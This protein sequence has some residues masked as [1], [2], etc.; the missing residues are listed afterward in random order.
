LIIAVIF[1]AF[2]GAAVEISYHVLD[3]KRL[4]GAVRQFSLI[5]ESNVP[6]WYSALLLTACALSLGVI[7]VTRPAGKGNYR[8]HWLILALIFLYMSMDEAAIIHEMTIRPIRDALH[9][10]GALY[11]AWTLPAAILMAIFLLSYLGF[12][13]HLPA[14]SR[15]RFILA[16][17]I[18][19]G[20]AFGTELIIGYLRDSEGYKFAS[21]FFSA[22]QEIMEMS[23]SSLFLAALL[24]HLA[25]DGG[26]IRIK[27][28]S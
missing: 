18:F 21:I 24:R 13:R 7:G 5:R 15:N 17:L 1:L 22:F 20:G 27:I 3:H 4:L 2:M 26:Q 11:Y 8:R 10:S 14:S 28:R 19:V 12:L 25:A 9:L 16:G 23:G 6:T